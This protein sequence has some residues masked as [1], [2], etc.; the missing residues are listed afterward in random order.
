MRTLLSI[1]NAACKAIA[2]GLA[3][4]LAIPTAILA[5]TVT[6]IAYSIDQWLGLGFFMLCLLIVWGMFY[7]TKD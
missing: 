4:I 3:I 5:M 2:W 7:A 6:S 1:V